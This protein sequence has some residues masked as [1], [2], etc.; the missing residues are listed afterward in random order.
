MRAA[1]EAI[2]GIELLAGSEVN[3]MPD[4]S[5]DYEPGKPETWKAAGSIKAASIDTNVEPR[6]KHLRSADFFDVEK[7]PTI[8]FK[9]TKVLESTPPPPRAATRVVREPADVAADQVV[10]FLAERRII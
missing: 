9:T 4:G 8:D 1:N 6:D 7:Y 10:A 2:E 3:V 5:L